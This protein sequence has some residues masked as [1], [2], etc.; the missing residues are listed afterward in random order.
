MSLVPK[1][2]SR[3]C[4][5]LADHALKCCGHANYLLLLQLLRYT[6][7]MQDAARQRQ[8]K[9]ITIQRQRTMPLVGSE[10]EQADT[11]LCHRMTSM[12]HQVHPAEEVMTS[13]HSTW[14][15]AG[16]KVKGAISTCRCN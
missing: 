14:A 4:T 9:T 15:Q 11:H 1:R 5:A 2:A 7:P 13:W 12:G 6:I 3:E 10:Q 8:H 16:N